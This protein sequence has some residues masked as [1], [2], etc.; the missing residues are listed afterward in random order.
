MRLSEFHR[1]ATKGKLES[2]QSKMAGCPSDVSSYMPDQEFVELLWEN[3]QIVMQ[4]QSNRPKKS[5]HLTHFPSHNLRA[6]EKD[7]RD[8]A[9]QK[10][11]QFDAIHSPV[12]DLSPAVPCANIGLSAQDDDMN[13]WINYP[14]EDPL[15]SEFFS[16]LAGIN[17][18]PPLTERNNGFAVKDLHNVENGLSSKSQREDTEPNRL[19]ANQLFQSSQQFP[20]SIANTKSRL[21]GPSLDG[22]GTTSSHQ[23]PLQRQDLVSTSKPL[24]SSS[25]IG[26]MNFSHFSRPTSFTR[27]NTAAL[28]RMKAN[29]KVST[30]T[31]RTNPVESTLMESSGLRAGSPFDMQKVEM[32][33]DAKPRGDEAICREDASRSNHH[34]HSVIGN[35]SSTSPEHRINHQSSSFAASVAVGRN[36]REKGHEAVVASS[37]CS[38]NSTGDASHDP[39]QRSKR[40]IREGDESGCHSED[41]DDESTGLKKPAAGRGGTSMKRSRAAEVHNLSER[42]RRDR[43]N[44]K[45]RALQELIPNCNKVDKASMLDEAI[46]Y[47][48]TLQLQ[49]QMMSMGNGLC[50]PPMMLSPGMQHIRAPPMAHFSPMG[51]GMGMGM[52]MGMGMGLNYGMGMLDMSGSPSCPL[53]PV[54]PMHTSQFPCSSMPATSGLNGMPGSTSL[55]LFGIPGH[56]Q[57]LPMSVSRAPLFSPISGYAAKGNSMNEVSGTMGNP[58]SATDAGPSRTNDRSQQQQCSNLDNKTSNT[59]SQGVKESAEQACLLQTGNQTSHASRNAAMNSFSDAGN[60]SNR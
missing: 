35:K 27:A 38:G 33:S 48:K 59:E 54:A 36:E 57:G 25:G 53:I 50:M 4:G 19:R 20:N 29:E 6:Q 12:N 9:I 45:M 16:E 37:V 22:S 26:L 28:D 1:S 43:I 40:K 14:M 23:G 18:N 39:K 24:A 47:L 56:G 10:F 49:V 55:Q 30:V 52:S 34:G 42:R 2:T 32:R 60:V 46:E 3:G 15:C 21:T 8:P 58:L 13:P 5:S 31:N 17:P 44:E 51:L 41:L 7:G 11:A